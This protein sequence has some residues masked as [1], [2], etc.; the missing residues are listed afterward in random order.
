MAG[1]AAGQGERRAAIL[2]P[3]TI[4]HLPT[5][6]TTDCMCASMQLSGQDSAP[7]IHLPRISINAFVIIPHARYLSDIVVYVIIQEYDQTLKTITLLHFLILFQ[8][9]MSYS[10]IY[11][12]DASSTHISVC[13]HLS[14]CCQCVSTCQ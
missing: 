5:G 14:V 6:G 12:S 4:K 10:V 3:T 13:L 11:L 1:S 2:S 7:C 9:V 8:A